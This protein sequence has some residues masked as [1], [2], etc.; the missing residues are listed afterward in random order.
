MRSLMAPVRKTKKSKKTMTMPVTVIL[1]VTNNK[2]VGRICNQAPRINDSLMSAWYKKPIPA[3]Y[4]YDRDKTKGKTNVTYRRTR[5]Q[6]VE[7]KRLIKIINKAIGSKEVDQILV[8]KGIMRMGTGAVTR[9]PFSSVNGCDELS[10]S[11]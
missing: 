2:N 3:G 5:A 11:K 4:L 7:D 10:I 9:L 6:K 1:T 8:L